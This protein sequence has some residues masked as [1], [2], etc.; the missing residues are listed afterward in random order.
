MGNIML[1]KHKSVFGWVINLFS[2]EKA[3][4]MSMLPI[5]NTCPQDVGHLL[6]HSTVIITVYRRDCEDDCSRPQQQLISV[7]KS[8]RLKQ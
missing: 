6:F 7:R 2:F 8:T 3:K 1:T 4:T 5:N